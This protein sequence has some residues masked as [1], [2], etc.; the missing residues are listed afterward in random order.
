MN[1]LSHIPGAPKFIDDPGAPE[2]YA[3]N[4]SGIQLSLGNAVITLESVRADHSAG[5][6]AV[7]RVVVGRIVLPVAVAHALVLQLHELLAQSGPGWIG[8][9]RDLATTQ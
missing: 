3:S 7:N 2:I 9:A 8:S 6:G 4:F 1:T 5:A